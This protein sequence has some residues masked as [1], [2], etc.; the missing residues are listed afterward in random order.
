MKCAGSHLG[1]LFALGYFSG[2]QYLDATRVTESRLASSPADPADPAAQ[3]HRE[4]NSISA[5]SL[6]QT[7]MLVRLCTLQLLRLVQPA[8]HH[9]PRQAQAS[10]CMSSPSAA[11]S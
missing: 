6:L 8:H 10:T 11:G 9:L 1:R 3:L 7:R 2:R 5:L 4:V